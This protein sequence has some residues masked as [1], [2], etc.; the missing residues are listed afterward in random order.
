[1]LASVAQKTGEIAP[2]TTV[3]VAQKMYQTIAQNASEIAQ[4]LLVRMA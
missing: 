1:M 3:R 4:L 2:T